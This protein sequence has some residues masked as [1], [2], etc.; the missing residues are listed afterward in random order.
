MSADYGLCG[1]TPFSPFF[2]D[3]NLTP[4]FLYL[5]VG[6]LQAVYVL[7]FGIAEAVRVRHCLPAPYARRP[8]P[9]STHFPA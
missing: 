8:F 7:T 3:G 1:S 5:Y 4:C 6:A 9:A 2:V